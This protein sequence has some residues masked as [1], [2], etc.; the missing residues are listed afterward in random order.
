ML[1]EFHSIQTT[2]ASYADVV[3]P[4]GHNFLDTFGL[5]GSGSIILKTGDATGGCDWRVYGCNQNPQVV[6][7]ADRAWVLLA[8]V[9]APASAASVIFGG[10]SDS[11]DH[12]RFW[13]YKTMIQFH[14]GGA[15]QSVSLHGVAK[16]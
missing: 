7:E 5:T 12:L 3:S 2:A 15:A 11:S 14:S 16:G 6:K 1:G 8:S 10:A 4:D 13:C 9:T